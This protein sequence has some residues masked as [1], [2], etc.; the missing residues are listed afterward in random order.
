MAVALEPDKAPEGVAMTREELFDLI[1]AQGV[2]A[3]SRRLGVSGSYLARVCI[4]LEVPRPKRG[5][6]GLQSVGRAPPKPTLPPPSPFNPGSWS[7]DKSK[8]IS[9][10]PLYTRVFR[11]Q[12][13]GEHQAEHPLVS[14]TRRHLEAAAR[15]SD[16]V[17]EYL[18][19]PNR[20]HRADVT[21]SGRGLPSAL[22]FADR[23]FMCLEAR[24]HNVVIA[25]PVQKLARASIDPREPSPSGR[26]QR[27]EF[28]VAARQPTVVYI[29]STPVGLAIVETS[30]DVKVQ[31][32]GYGKFVPVT[33]WKGRHV[34]YTWS[35]LK[36]MPSGRFRLLAYDPSRLEGW[37][38]VWQESKP[39][40]LIG[41][42]DKIA[43]EL[44]RAAKTLRP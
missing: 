39:D 22:E 4:A 44:E 35:T 32:A 3:T 7:R 19:L 11:N 21:V 29:G 12:A 30:K 20:F 27:E 6:W 23:L 38:Y 36:E 40:E 31:Y 42:V 37:R 18:R 28:L 24:G 5:H 9:M 2:A 13:A 10:K 43:R 8:R 26:R 34:G 17:D 1:W 33:E 41:R 25:D 15:R 16:D 14:L